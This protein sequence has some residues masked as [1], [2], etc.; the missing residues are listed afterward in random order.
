MHQEIVSQIP[1]TVLG[2]QSCR[3][4]A[5]WPCHRSLLGTHSTLSPSHPLSLSHSGHA[6]LEAVALAACGGN[7]NKFATTW[8]LWGETWHKVPHATPVGSMQMHVCACQ[9]ACLCVYVQMHLPFYAPTLSQHNFK[10]CFYRKLSQLG[11]GFASLC[12]AQSCP[13]LPC[14]G[15]FPGLCAC[16]CLSLLVSACLCLSTL[17]P[18]LSH[19][20][21]A[22]AFFQFANWWPQQLPF[23]HQLTPR[24]QAA[25]CCLSL[26]LFSPSLSLSCCR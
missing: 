1:T 17:V 13:V 19:P 3:L 25:P 26:L 12:C 9:R 5:V 22:F 10:F 14:L 11:F 21:L 16:L 20:W 7:E 4:Y 23:D 6:G 15:L 24:P 18:S 8:W 2:M